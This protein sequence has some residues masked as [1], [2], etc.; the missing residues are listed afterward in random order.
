MNYA[1]HTLCGLL[2]TYGLLKEVYIARLPVGHTHIDIDGRHAIFS[3]HFNGTKDSGGRVVNGIMTPAEFD[4]EIK[5][6][7]KKDRVT[8]FRKYGLLAFSDKVKGWLGFSNYGTPTKNSAHAILQG[9][10]D[11]EAHYFTYYRDPALGCSR[12]RYKFAETDTF[13]LPVNEGIMV[14]TA[15]HIHDAMDLLNGD[16]DMKA[17]DEW[18]N[19]GAVQTNILGSKDLTPIQLEEWEEWFASCPVSTDDIDAE[20]DKC[21]VRWDVKELLSKRK[22]YVEEQRA[23]FTPWTA[24]NSTAQPFP[25]EIIVHPGHTKKTLNAERKQRQ[26]TFQRKKAVEKEAELVAAVLDGE[27]RSSKRKRFVTS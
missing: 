23:I 22:E 20:D 4:R 1:L 5:A 19:R 10:R 26:E 16:I 14:I 15:D 11:P 24:Q 27:K 2:T 21:I 9:G 17:M 7:Y 18:T 8:V 6:P 13:A 3:M 25:H 12:M